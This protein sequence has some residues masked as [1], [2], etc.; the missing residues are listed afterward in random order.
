[1]LSIW[2]VQ[3]ILRDSRNIILLF[4]QNQMNNWPMQLDNLYEVLHVKRVKK[5]GQKF[6]AET[7]NDDCFGRESMM[8]ILWN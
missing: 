3:T 5:R 6:P 7:G 2:R 8:R 4:V 1:M